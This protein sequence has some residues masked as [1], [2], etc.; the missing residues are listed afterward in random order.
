MQEPP[1]I[2][3]CTNSVRACWTFLG[4]TVKCRQEGTVHVKLWAQRWGRRE[5]GLLLGIKTTSHK[6]PLLQ[7]DVS[8]CR[9]RGGGGGGSYLYTVGWTSSS[10]QVGSCRTDAPGGWGAC[11]WFAP[12]T[13]ARR[14]GPLPG[15]RRVQALPLSRDTESRPPAWALRERD[16]SSLRIGQLSWGDPRR[17]GG[18]KKL[19]RSSGSLSSDAFSCCA[20]RGRCR[21][22]AR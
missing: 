2:I 4:P 13:A 11:R 5:T 17:T 22:V 1:I 16:S 9:F 7:T 12:R 15:A 3:S 21:L 8:S 20:A 18:G 14:S 19:V 10:L 6:D